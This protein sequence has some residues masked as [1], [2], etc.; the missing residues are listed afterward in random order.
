VNASL[1]RTC[2]I[3]RKSMLVRLCFL[4]NLTITCQHDVNLPTEI[5]D[6]YWDNEQDP[7]H[8]FKQPPGKYSLLSYF[9]CFIK[10]NQILAVSLRTIVSHVSISL[11][12]SVFMVPHSIRLA[13][14]KF[15]LGLWV[16]T[17]SSG[18]ARFRLNEWIDMVPNPHAFFT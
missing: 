8:T 11:R 14:R 6:E 3:Q 1:G 5:D 10:F 18:R 16:R 13:R 2:A 15:S 4:P 7:E 17:G 12:L 9:V